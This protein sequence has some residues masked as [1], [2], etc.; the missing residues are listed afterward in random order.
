MST[1]QK[2]LFHLRIW[3]FCL[4]FLTIL[5]VS[6]T[7]TGK[8]TGPLGPYTTVMWCLYF[9]FALA[10]F[11]GV[12]TFYGKRQAV[13]TDKVTQLT[14]FF[15]PTVAR[16]DT[17]PGLF[18]VI[19]SILQHAPNNLL[20][21][22]VDVTID[23]WAPG[24][25]LLQA[26]YG[27]NPHVR[28]VVIPA[29]Y[30]TANSTPYKARAN[31]YTLER[32]TLEHESRSDVFVYHLDDDTAVGADT[33]AAIAEFLA[34]DDGTSYHLGQGV[35]TFPHENSANRWC[36]LAD[37]VRPADDLSRF[38][39]FTGVLK[40]PLVGLHGEHLIV[41]A[42]IEAEIGWDFGPE[43]LTEDAFFALKFYEHYRHHT[44]FLNGCT[45]GASPANVSDFVKQRRRWATGLMRMVLDRR[46]TFKAKGVMIGA[47][48]V[49]A[50][51]P[52]QHLAVVITAGVILHS[53]S[54][55]PLTP[56][57]L[58]V[59]AFNMAWIMWQYFE[60]M[61]VNLRVSIKP[62]KL[63]A[64]LILPVMTLCALLEAYASL[65]G[66]LD[67]IRGK[68]RGFEVIRKEV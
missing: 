67:V 52:F 10:G 63:L 45:Y 17:L 58:P 5:A 4:M 8:P 23:V 19:D 41:R 14:L 20:N 29:D 48:I 44:R 28:V 56:V 32:R 22:R 27:G 6:I 24:G 21:W 49:W 64:W 12:S 47:T 35:L 59:W 34:E 31:Q 42:S 61:H 9:P 11:L 18:R 26:R 60:G 2:D 25:P 55:A 1:K 40:K 43:M 46:L 50:S 39:F 62:D 37:A 33:I 3:L 65:L 53:L 57:V 66:L 15:I 7:I 13:S 68:Q 54:T 36:K 51:G 38:H 30:Q 16:L